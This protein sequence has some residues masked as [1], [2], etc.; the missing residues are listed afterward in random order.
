MQA[1]HA[2]MLQSPMPAQVHAH[3]CVCSM[4]SGAIQQGVP[5]KVL[6]AICWLPQDPP[7]SMVAATPKS[8]RS[9]CP[10]FSIKMLPACRSVRTH[11]AS[12][13]HV[14]VPGWVWMSL[15]QLTRRKTT[16]TDVSQLAAPCVGMGALLMPGS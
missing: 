1:T 16:A 5:T 4:T 10:S 7:R 14:S 11:C 13:L 12:D 3:P 15:Q 8:A 2:N 9:T 6:R